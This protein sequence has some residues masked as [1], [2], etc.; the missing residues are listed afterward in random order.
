[1][2]S[3]PQPP[4]Q[5]AGIEKPSIEHPRGLAGLIILLVIVAGGTFALRPFYGK[6]LAFFGVGSA[7]PTP[8][9]Q[10]AAPVEDPAVTRDWERYRA[11]GLLKIS[12]ETYL[13]D[14][15]GYP[16]SLDKLVPKY[17]KEIPKDP[18]TATGYAY[19]L[20]DDGY[21]ISFALEKGVLALAPGNHT[22]TSHG[23]DVAP[24]AEAPAEN[25]TETI[26]DA[27][28]G[29]VTPQPENPL[30]PIP[31]D[32]ETDNDGDG[33]TDAEEAAQSTDPLVAD[34]DKDGLSDGDEVHRFSTNPVLADT[35]ADGFQDGD[36]LYRGTDPLAAETTLPD[37]DGDGLADMF[38]DWKSL[39]A[40][41]PDID[42]DALADGDEVRVYGTDPKNRDTD[43]DGFDDKTEI[44]NGFNPS[45]DGRLSEERKLDIAAAETQ[46][47]LHPPTK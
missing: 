45:G 7:K 38:E 36:E 9:A 22:L 5:P 28:T 17:I 2:D 15:G 18:T 6:I 12:L 27:V 40:V 23:F 41:N 4:P 47:G 1:M 39:D 24:R 19:V 3:V 31:A 43:G 32:T 16:A 34:T 42:G 25:T 11:M 21:T 13:H 26:R 33:L 20:S 46:F 44:T 35:D 29:E 10:N 37:R 14:F 30:P 8:T